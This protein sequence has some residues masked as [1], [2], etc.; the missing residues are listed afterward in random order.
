M[1]TI[2]TVFSK[3][4]QKLKCM[5]TEERNISFNGT[6]YAVRIGNFIDS[7]QILNLYEDNKLFSLIQIPFLSFSGYFNLKPTKKYFLEIFDPY[8]KKVHI[9]FPKLKKFKIYTL[10]LVYNSDKKTYQLIVNIDRTSYSGNNLSLPEKPSKKVQ[11]DNKDNLDNT[12][13]NLNNANINNLTRYSGESNMIT[14]EDNLDNT[15]ENLDNF[16]QN[17]LARYSGKPNVTKNKIVITTEI[18]K[19]TYKKEIKTGDELG[20]GTDIVKYTTDQTGNIVEYT[21]DQT[22]DIAKHTTDQTG[23]IVEYTIE[24]NSDVDNFAN[25][26]IAATKYTFSFQIRYFRK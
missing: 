11:M 16:N 13:E 20:K 25:E 5:Q 1:I 26:T 8:N 7:A 19:Q 15:L 23:D 22:G 9:P 24:Q 2:K 6:Y 18:L 17:K 21:I 4:A 10:F 14:I 12:L 3:G